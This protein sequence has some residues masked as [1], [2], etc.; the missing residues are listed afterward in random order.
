MKRIGIIDIGTNSILFLLT[1]RSG[2]GKIHSIR[3]ESRTVRLGRGLVT[4]G[5]ILA[6]SIDKCVDVL[7]HYRREAERERVDNLI[8]VGTHVF[9]SAANRNEVLEYIHAHTGIEVEIL[10][11]AE[12][13]EWCYR[14]AVIH[15]RIGSS[16]CVLD[17]GGGS[18]EIIRGNADRIDR[19]ESI[20][21]GCVSL[22]ERFLIHDPPGEEE[23]TRAFEYIDLNL[24]R[25]DTAYFGECNTWI[26]TGGS[27]TSLAAL[28]LGLT[29]YDPDRVDGH[30]LSRKEVQRFTDRFNHKNRSSRIEIMAFDPERADVISAGTMILYKIMETENFDTITVSDRGLRF[31]IALRTFQSDSVSAR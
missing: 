10:T 14:G 7:N 1:G 25:T 31:G 8:C 2:S 5:R 22:T 24:Q 27:V 17:I 9:R 4:G 29:R 13:A 16:A 18:T 12:E 11:E 23:I 20:A 26:G 6:V 30:V 28:S 19:I 21:L 15:R 3:Q